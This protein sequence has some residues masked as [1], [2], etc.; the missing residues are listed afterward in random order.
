[1]IREVIEDDKLELKLKDGK[2]LK[3]PGKAMVAAMV[4]KANAGDV[5]AATFL[6]KYGYGDK[7]DV[8]SNDQTLTS[9]TIVA[10][11]ELADDFASYL[12][13]K[14]KAVEPPVDN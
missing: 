7:L 11:K 6:A 10:T 12:K 5:P 9:P 14:T 3:G 8:T 13:D 4:I 2:L 1:M